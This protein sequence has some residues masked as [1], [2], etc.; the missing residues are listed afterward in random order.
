[1]IKLITIDVDGTLVNNQ[2]VIT[3]RTREALLKAQEKGITVTIATGRP[4]Y[5]IDQYVDVLKLKEYEGFVCTYNGGKIIDC[6][7][8]EVVSNK[9]IDEDLVTKVLQKLKTLPVSTYVYGEDVLYTTG[10]DAYKYDYSDKAASGSIEI[11]PN[12]NDNFNSKTNKILISAPHE[13]LLKY[14]DILNEDFKDKLSLTFSDPFYYEF[15]PKNVNKGYGITKLMNHLNIE[16]DEVLAFGDALNDKEMIE[17]AGIGVAMKNR[18]K[19]LIKV[20]DYVT[21]SNEEDG[22]AYYLEKYVLD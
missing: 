15:M 5:G 1:M 10:K 17:V 4:E 21:L 22:I 7:T 19:N 14:V 9:L 16:K 13:V 20:S 12:L 3:K 11:D 18:D 8:K 2:K 6:K